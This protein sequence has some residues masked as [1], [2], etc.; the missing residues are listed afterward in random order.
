MD[1]RF[2]ICGIVV[3]AAALILGVA[4]HGLLLRPDYQ[5]LA[6]LYRT[7]AQADAHA[8]WIL[9]A[10]LL[11]GLSMTWLYRRMPAS[12]GVDLGRGARFGLAIA[13]VSYVPWHIFAFVA[14]PLPMSLMLRQVALD[15]VAMLLLGMLLAW[16]Q[17]HR[18]V[19]T[20]PP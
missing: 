3:A 14:Q 8:A 6:P 15:L 11:L 16:L 7:P 18:R 1:K 10:Y 9:P 19:L 5:A 17:P 20:D 4:V 12:D 2:L 13:L